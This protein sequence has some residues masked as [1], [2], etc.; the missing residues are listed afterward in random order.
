MD[1]I[2]VIREYWIIDRGPGFFFSPSYDLAPPPVSKLSLFL[3]LRVCRQ[4]VVSLSQ[5]SCMSSVQLT[6]GREG[7]RGLGVRGRAKYYDGE[8]ADPLKVYLNTLWGREQDPRK[9]TGKRSRPFPL[10][11]LF[12]DVGHLKSKRSADILKYSL[13]GMKNEKGMQLKLLMKNM[14]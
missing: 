9:T 8:K 13:Y 11:F 5:S 7:C 2:N 1:V 14:M 3:N 10:L 12:L 4:Q 6:D